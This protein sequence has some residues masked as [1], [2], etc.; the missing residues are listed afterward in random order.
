LLS[1][2]VEDVIKEYKHPVVTVHATVPLQECLQK[3]VGVDIHGLAVVDS[4]GKLV[5]QFEFSSLR[6]LYQS[7][8]Q[9]MGLGVLAFLAKH[10]ATAKVGTPLTVETSVT[11]SQLIQMFAKYKVHRLWVVDKEECPRAL[12]EVNDIMKLI[13]SG[14]RV[15]ETQI[16]GGITKLW[17]AFQTMETDST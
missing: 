3:L 10:G 14:E 4:N 6:G 16:S 11:V 8:I 5:Q 9:N 15:T 13:A 12:V 2:T 17:H 7:E 1:K